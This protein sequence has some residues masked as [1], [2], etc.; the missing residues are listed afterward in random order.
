LSASANLF[1]AAWERESSGT[2]F[3]WHHR[4]MHR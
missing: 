3:S 1:Q 2:R 4:A